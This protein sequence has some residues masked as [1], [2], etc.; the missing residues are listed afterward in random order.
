MHLTITSAWM[1]ALS[2]SC[3]EIR[4]RGR[5]SSRFQ[6]QPALRSS[7][8]IRF[9][10]P[11]ECQLLQTRDADRG[12]T[13][14]QAI[15]HRHP[16]SPNRHTRAAVSWRKLCGGPGSKL[17]PPKSDHFCTLPKTPSPAKKWMLL[18]STGAPDIPASNWVSAPLFANK[19]PFWN[20][21]E[22]AG[23]AWRGCCEGVSLVFGPARLSRAGTG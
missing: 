3:Q 23:I 12:R 17:S 19:P 8:E 5:S 4:T 1:K 2:A 16:S 22:P 21:G 11:S 15:A 20:I 6:T 9:T 10:H 14:P 13:F 18:T 7:A